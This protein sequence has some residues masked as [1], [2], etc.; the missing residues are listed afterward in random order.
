ML[1]VMAIATPPG[2]AGVANKTV[3]SELLPPMISTGLKVSDL[4]S[5][6]LIVIIAVAVE[7]AYFPVMTAWVTAPTEIVFRVKLAEDFPAGTFN[8]IGTDATA[9]E[10]VR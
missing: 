5:G 7:P 6:G 8:A 2:G 9:L 4:I 3:A 1:L 10:L